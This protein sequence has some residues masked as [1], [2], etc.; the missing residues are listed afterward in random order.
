MVAM[1]PDELALLL[2]RLVDRLIRRCR[3]GPAPERSRR[4]RLL[5]VQI[6][7]LSRAVLEYALARGYM[8]FL[9]RLLRRQG[10]RLEPMSVGLPTS[11]P[12]FQMGAFYGVEPDIPGFHYHDKRRGD[13]VYFPR[14]GD[15][16]WVERPRPGPAGHPRERQRLRLR[17][18]RRRGEQPVQLRQPQAPHRRGA[19]ARPGGVRGAGLGGDQGHRSHPGRAGRAP[20]FGFFADPVGE[21]ARGWKWLALKI[22]ISVW[23]RHLFTLATSRDLYAGVPAVYVNYLDYDVFAHAFGPRH[24]R[25]LRSL[26]RIDRSIR[27]LWRCYA[28]S[29]S[30]ATTLCAVRPRP[31]EDPALRRGLRRTA[32]GAGDLRGSLEAGGRVGPGSGPGRAA[33]A[34]STASRPTGASARPGSCSASSTIWSATF[35]GRWASFPKPRSGRACAWCRPVPTPSSTS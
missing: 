29:P 20:C 25:A 31:G 22:G 14:G 10:F 16:A 9:A 24:R 27:A 35:P 6:D 28:G 13:D 8:P 34:W 18:H 12:T 1:S 26:R 3:L 2:Q 7:G 21:T 11:T 4:R 17:L 32:A 15:A 19:P 33:P 5:V 23:V 30:T